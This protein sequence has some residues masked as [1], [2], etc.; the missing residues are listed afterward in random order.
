MKSIEIAILRESDEAIQYA[1]IADGIEVG[2]ASVLLG[3][4]GAY[5]ERIDI[6]EQYRNRGFGTAFLKALSEIHSDIYVAPDNADAQRLYDRLGYDV[7]DNGD[8]Y[9][10]D[11]GFGVY[12]I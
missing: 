4:D 2:Q 3:E 9:M 1:A 6:D 11:Q 5:C 10:V 12:R 7:T 8:W